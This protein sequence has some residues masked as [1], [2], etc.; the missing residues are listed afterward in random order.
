MTKSLQNQQFLLKTVTYK[1]YYRRGHYRR[2]ITGFGKQLLEPFPVHLAC[3]SSE[4][5]KA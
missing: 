1:H 5:T 4:I 3:D 2:R